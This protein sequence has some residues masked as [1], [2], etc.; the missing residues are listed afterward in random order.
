MRWR[1]RRL[2][3]HAATAAVATAA[4]ATAAVAS[5]AAAMMALAA[6][7]AA[8]REGE[9][10]E[11]APEAEEAGEAEAEAVVERVTEGGAEGEEGAAGERRAVE[12]GVEE[13]SDAGRQHQQVAGYVHE[14][15]WHDCSLL[16]LRISVSAGAVRRMKGFILSPEN[17]FC[18]KLPPDP[19]TIQ[20]SNQ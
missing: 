19:L 12:V 18:R 13:S 8:V 5:M 16:L 17:I 11:A 4:V 14:R 15:L 1:V 6:A 3:H 9:G 2:L 20:N 10:T 7:A